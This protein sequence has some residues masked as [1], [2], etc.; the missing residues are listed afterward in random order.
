M[1]SDS[2]GTPCD[3]PFVWVL[4]QRTERYV[5]R[6]LRLYAMISSRGGAG[7]SAL[8]SEQFAQSAADEGNH[9]I[10]P[11]S[12]L[13]AHSSLLYSTLSS[14]PLASLPLLVSSRVPWWSA[15]ASLRLLNVSARQY[16]HWL[17][18][19][20]NETGSWR[21]GS[22]SG[23]D[24]RWQWTPKLFRKYPEACMGTM[25][26]RLSIYSLLWYWRG[27]WEK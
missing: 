4:G 23:A 2:I 25:V 8:L 27:L 15:R 1:K 24:R 20:S 6:V 21:L 11:C 3:W 13:Q 16:N 10:S 18:D 17:L 12:C 9:P 19:S 26:Y 7:K 5:R 14:H 22:W